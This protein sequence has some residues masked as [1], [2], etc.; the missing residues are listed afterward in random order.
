MAIYQTLEQANAD[1]H[2]VEVK[3]T[4]EQFEWTKQWYPLAVVEYLDSS[5]PHSMQLLG[6]NIVLWCDNQGKWNCFEDACPHRL[7][8]FSEGRVED[9]GTL[10]CAYHAWR[11]NSEGKCV[12]IP[13]SKDK[14][15]EARNCA[16]SKS[17]AKVYPTQIRQGL[18]WVWGESGETAS[19][20]SKLRQPR[21]VPE[22]EESSQQEV[23][24]LPWKF[25][26]LPHGWVYYIE[27][28]I[29]P[30]HVPVAHH[31]VMGN[32]YTDPKYYD[33]PRE[34][35]LSTQE[36]FSFQVTPTSTEIETTIY[37]F[38]PPCHVRVYNVDKRGCKVIVILYAVPTRPGWCRYIGTQIFVKNDKGESANGLGFFGLLPMPAWLHHILES[39][40]L[41]QDAV[42]LHYQEKIIADHSQ[43]TWLDK[44]YTPNPQDKMVV[45]FRHWLEKRAGGGIP[46][47]PECN[48]DVLPTEYDR[49]KLFD[50]WNTHTKNCT[51]C[52]NALKNINR[53]T[54]LSYAVSIACLFLAVF[55][56]ARS[57]AIAATSQQANLSVLSHSMGFWLALGGG[58]SGAVIGYLLGKISKMFYVYEFSHSDSK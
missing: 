28:V 26:D 8:P 49:R 24:Q 17:C 11:F 2:S 9:D 4:Q 36:G 39:V 48:P 13:Q 43:A 19:V 20:E 25:R 31:G 23:S 18:L 10:L 52:Q 57:L 58:I 15:T 7:V 54:K 50:V 5:R 21:I 41:H 37:D 34:R 1:M 12:S 46:W 27:N 55:L 32:R 56:D 3:E 30:A 33:M 22:L 53:A 44:V 51:A 14:E 35:K 16:N 42:F 6:K 47:A 40:F 29:D 45:T 38:Q